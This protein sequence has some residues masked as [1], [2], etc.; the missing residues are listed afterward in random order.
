MIEEKDPKYSLEQLLE[1]KS[2]LEA[3]LKK[4]FTRLITV[5]FTDFAGSTSMTEE[6]GDMASRMSLKELN[7]IIFPLISAQ[8]GVLV[9]TMGDGTLSYFN[10]AQEALR[11]AVAVQRGVEGYNRDKGTKSPHL[12][13]IGLHS[14]SG[15]VESSD[16][17]GDVVNVASRIETLALPGE[18]CLSEDTF[19]RLADKAEFD[20]VFH[21]TTMI[22]GKKEVFKLYTVVWREKDAGRD[23][24]AASGADAGPDKETSRRRITLE[25]VHSRMLESSDFPAMSRTV[26]VFKKLPAKAD[27]NDISIAEITNT[28]LNDFALTNKLLKLVNTAFYTQ[29]DGKVTTISRAL[30][31]LGFIQVRNAALSLMMFENIQNKELADDLKLAIVNS[32][33]SAAAAR[34][35]ALKTGKVD[36]EESFICALF[37]DMGRLVATYYLPE[38]D[39]KISAMLA[40][41][42]VTD[43]G[44]RT[45]IDAGG[46]TPIDAGGRTPIDA[47][48][49][50]PDEDYVSRA[51]MGLSYEELGISIAEEWRLPA[52]VIASMRKPPE[53]GI[54][55]KPENETDRLNNVVNFSTELCS[56]IFNP[57]TAPRVK[58]NLIEGLVARAGQWMEFSPKDVS[59]M[60]E[61]LSGEFD[62]FTRAAGIKTARE[63]FFEKI[64]G[65]FEGVRAETA[66]AKPAPKPPPAE[67]GDFDDTTVLGPMGPMMDESEQPSPAKVSE[68]ILQKG[69]YEVTNTLL[70]EYSINDILRMILEIMYRGMGFFRVLICIRNTRHNAME[71]RFGFGADISTILKIFK[72]PLDN[73]SGDVFNATLNEGI[74][75]IITNT[76][77]PD[78]RSRIPDW[79]RNV[80]NAQSFIL[81]PIIINKIPLGLIY[82]D[83]IYAGQSPIPAHYIWHLKTLRKLAVL[84]FKQK[85]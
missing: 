66:K 47:G 76:G 42:G 3:L 5:M 10:G 58:R 71:G 56:I 75:F 80:I 29:Y 17:F 73:L 36:A 26:E 11:C 28:I 60:I 63:P 67:G 15:I 81:L 78:I 55:S 83:K 27:Y 1:Q 21:K 31:L 39:R 44:G 9:K 19:S 72:Y 24:D 6:E 68:L 22:K 48:G 38:D 41:G 13:R 52:Q 70:D 4:E 79:Y 30:M 33:M 85:L 64:T 7:D 2:R 84:A 14:G 77:A 8:N 34:D 25:T 62:R 18:I 32:F 35:L 53:G 45:P 82:A 51:V 69:I 65:L 54:F 12:I 61:K 40:R 23:E 50:T 16:I 46:R 74:D 43:A 49:R 37:H 59:R 20:V 57:N